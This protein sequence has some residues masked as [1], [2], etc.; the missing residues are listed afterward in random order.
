M[1]AFI[2]YCHPSEESF[3]SYVRDSFIK[4]IIDSGNEYVISDLYKMNFKS[5]MTEQEY[6]RDA[7]YRTAPAVAA[8][9]LAEHEKINSA[10]AIVF[11]YPVF[12]T[13]APAKLVGWFDRVWSYGFA[14]GENRKMKMLEKGLILCSAG[15]PIERLEEFGLL[16]SMKKVMLG[17]RLFNRVKQAD[18]IVFDSTSRENPLREKNWDVNLKKAYEIGKNMFM[19]KRDDIEISKYLSETD[20]IDFSNPVIQEKVLELK[21]SAASELDYIEK[22]YEFVRDDIPHS[23]DI[24]SQIVSRKA[25]EVLINKTGICW[26]KSCLLAALL[27]ANNIPAG[28]SY[29]YLT[30]ADDA[31]DGYIIHAL[32]TVYI[33]SLKKWIR[34]DA[35]GNK[36]GV[37]AQFCLAEEK[38]AFPARPEFGEKDYRDNHSDLDSRLKEILNTSKSILE[39][40]TDFEI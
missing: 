38:L 27:R 40:R 35:R 25:S 6:L 14:Y 11:I 24:K 15:N 12:W 1:K 2:V 31:S 20:C 17:D 29:Q 32:N 33:D 4:G 39:V 26:T 37:N 30:R 8:D 22:A 36:P 3:T 19:K 34:L 23:W 16:D 13:E 7:N 10:D 28:I 5:D 18:F 9:V 21:Q